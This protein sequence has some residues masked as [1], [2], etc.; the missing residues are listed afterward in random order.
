VR[1]ALRAGDVRRAASLLGR[2]YSIG[3]RVAHGAE[4]GRRL[5]FPT[6]NIVPPS[7]W[8]LATGVYAGHADW[9]GGSA[10]AVINVGVRP[11]FDEAGL[12]VEAHLLDVSDDLYDRQLTLTFRD[13]IRDEMKFASVEALRRRIDEDVRAARRLLAG[14]AG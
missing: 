6:A 7:P 8:L 14:T 11:T 2:P 12:V 10:A 1:D 13:R 9:D 4:R 3:G 5:G